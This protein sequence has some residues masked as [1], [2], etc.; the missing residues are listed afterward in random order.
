MSE[1]DRRSNDDVGEGLEVDRRRFLQSMGVAT[2]GGVL[3]DLGLF[4]QMASAAGTTASRASHARPN[5]IVLVADELRFP[6]VFPAGIETPVEFLRKFMPNVY[7]LWKHGVKF[8]N[9]H[10]A[11]NA[12]SPSRATMVTGLYPHQEWILK[13]RTS[14]SPSLNPAFPTYGK[15]LRQ[16]GYRTPYIGKWHLSNPPANG[17]IAGYLEEYGFAGMTNPD[18][19]GLN[20]QGAGDDPDIASQ[21]ISWLQTH[22]PTAEPYC[23]TVSLVNPHDKQYFWAGTERNSFEALFAG[24]FLRPLR[25]GYMSVTG[26]DAPPS[27][28]YPTLPPN[29]ES[30]ADLR[31]HRKP[32]THRLARYFQELVWGG[33]PDSPTSQF[34]VEPYPG[35]PDKL[36]I[37]IAPFSYWQ[38][39]LDMYTYAMTLVDYQIGRVVASIPKHQLSN[40]V[41]VVL[42]DHGEFAGAHGLLS[43]KICTAY[44]EA[45][46]VPLIVADPGGRFTAHTDVERAQLTSSADFMPMLVSLA[47]GGSRSWMRGHLAEIYGQRL[48]MIPLLRN[49]RAAGRQ[50]LLFGT[51]EIIPL[52]M[53]YLGAPTHV[54]GVQTPNAKLCTYTDWVPGTAVPAAGGMQLEF[55]DYSTSLGRAELDSEP[56]DPRVRG[57]V[58][59]LFERYVPGEFRAPLPTPALRVA[60][61][62]ARSA[63]LTALALSNALSEIE[64]IDQRK[65]TT[66]VDYG[67]NM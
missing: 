52:A 39:G 66:M 1:G 37:G 64:L 18:P 12:C 54:L 45:W 13:T 4:D 7:E 3:G 58:R 57:L 50:Y 56:G 42:S 17:S 21:A 43:G 34:A 44:D 32:S 55:Y 11:G 23:L 8:T 29:W 30:V 61:R 26:E 51:D 62:R 10:T 40:T 24:K 15:L 59:K 27:L 49:P 38:R 63:Y 25:P 67:L 31:L 16:L 6:S 41:L 22:A 33:A 53:N 20:G 5:I 46:H 2:V 48:D 60:S 14:F 28:N 35:F 19:V 36:G 47:S 65:I 9:H